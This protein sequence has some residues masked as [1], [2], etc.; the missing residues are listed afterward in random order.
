MRR[1]RAR[2]VQGC[3]LSGR[4]SLLLCLAAASLWSAAELPLWS[5]PFTFTTLAGNAGYGSA[6]GVGTSARFDFPEGAGV[7]GNGNVYVA[8]TEN[9]TIRKITPGGR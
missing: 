9:S 1:V 4:R 5:Q 3:K 8:D 6:D 2:G 7:D